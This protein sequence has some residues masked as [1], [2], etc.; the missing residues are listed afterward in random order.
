[1]FWDAKRKSACPQLAVGLVVWGYEPLLVQA[2]GKPPLT[3]K[4]PLKT[5]NLGQ[6]EFVVLPHPIAFEGSH[7]W[8]Q[9]RGGTPGEGARSAG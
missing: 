5:R 8:R 3:S 4:P 2:Y 1:M 7:A 9:K 6:A